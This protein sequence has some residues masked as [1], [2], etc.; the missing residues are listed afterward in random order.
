MEHIRKLPGHHGGNQHTGRARRGG[1][2]DAGTIHETSQV[3]AAGLIYEQ[4]FNSP[5]TLNIA[6]I[7]KLLTSR[8]TN[9]TSAT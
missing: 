3:A 2:G 4:Q 1:A 7:T 8:P 6:T 9:P 5:E